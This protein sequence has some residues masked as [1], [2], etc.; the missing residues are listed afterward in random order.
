VG[1]PRGGGGG[2]P[3]TARWVLEGLGAVAAGVVLAALLAG[4]L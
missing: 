4:A 1:A 2:R 3:V